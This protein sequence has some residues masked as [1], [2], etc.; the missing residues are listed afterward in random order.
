MPASCPLHPRWR[1]SLSCNTG[2]PLFC[3]RRTRAVEGILITLLHNYVVAAHCPAIEE[4][5][6]TQLRLFEVLEGRYKLTLE[7]GRRIFQALN[8]DEETADLLDMTPGAAVMHLA[9]TTYLPDGAA[10]EYSDVWLR[11]SSFRLSATMLRGEAPAM[12]L[13]LLTKANPIPSLD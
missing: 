5:D 8:A 13:M 9:Q 3:L 6:F 10:V 4:T 11:G 12:D 7:R 1:R 2:V